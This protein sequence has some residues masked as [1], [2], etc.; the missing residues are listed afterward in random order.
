MNISHK[1][2]WFDGRS[3]VSFDSRELML[4]LMR[5]VSVELFSPEDS[6]VS[7]LIAKLTWEAVDFEMVHRKSQGED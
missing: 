4:N 5:G 7:I 6:F 1:P 3:K 2:E